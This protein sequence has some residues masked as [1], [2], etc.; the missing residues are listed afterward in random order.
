MV[1]DDALIANLDPERMS[2]VLVP[3]IK[4]AWNLH[5]LTRDQPLDHFML[6]SSM[7]TYIGNPGQANYVAG[8]AW[9]E[10]LAVLRRAHGLPVTCIGWGPIGDAGYLTRN[11]VVKDSLASRL[12]AEPLSAS[13]ALRMLGRALVASQPNLAIA[14]FQ[15]SALARLLP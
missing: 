9:L 14:D 6:Y 15:F 2:R 11:Q 10:G 3:K 5:E 12:G 13:G 8:N 1:I 4:G 7:T